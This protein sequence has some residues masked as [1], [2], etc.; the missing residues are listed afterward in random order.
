MLAEKWRRKFS[1]VSTVLEII[2]WVFTGLVFN[3]L[4]FEEVK[5]SMEAPPFI[6]PTDEIDLEENIEN[7]WSFIPA[8]ILQ[9]VWIIIPILALLGCA[10]VPKKTLEECK[11]FEKM[12][13]RLLYAVWLASILVSENFIYKCRYASLNNQ[14]SN[15]LHRLGLKLLFWF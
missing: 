3:V 7:P 2:F 13:G 12:S 6:A 10:A 11:E 8:P 14:L 4:L 5:V 1:G 15:N 9:L